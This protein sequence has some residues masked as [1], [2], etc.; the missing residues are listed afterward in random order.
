MN[1][2]PIEQMFDW[3]AGP[4]MYDMIQD[5]QILQAILRSVLA[6]VASS[7]E[8]VCMISYMILLFRKLFCIS[9]GGMR[10]I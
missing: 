7:V 3:R 4:S 9:H 2:C 6:L 10:L 5:P 1:K 8:L